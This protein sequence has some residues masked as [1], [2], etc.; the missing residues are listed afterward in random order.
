[1]TRIYSRLDCFRPGRCGQQS[2]TLEFYFKILD[3]TRT[4]IAEHRIQGFQDARTFT[5]TCR[6]GNTN[7]ARGCTGPGY[8]FPCT[9]TGYFGSSPVVSL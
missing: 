4:R 3:D 8:I 6:S 2:L 7:R 9:L 5:V 1:M